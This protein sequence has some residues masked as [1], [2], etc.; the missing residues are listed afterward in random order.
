MRSLLFA[1]RVLLGPSARI[2][3]GLF[4]Y[5][6]KKYKWAG[7]T[8]T[9][10]YILSKIMPALFLSCIVSYLVFSV[11]LVSAFEPGVYTIRNFGA[12]A[13]AS[14]GPPVPFIYLY[15]DLPVN[16]TNNPR[17]QDHWTVDASSNTEYR[18]SIETSSYATIVKNGSVFVSINGAANWSINS[19]VVPGARSLYT[20]SNTVGYWKLA[21]ENA[22]INIVT[23]LHHDDGHAYW[24]FDK[25]S[26]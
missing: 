4:H 21:S 6:A 14:V 23:E 11:W 1:S 5:V 18:V 19:V 15:P 13:N 24:S 22:Q 7:L 8:G 9:P 16:G 20:I 12:A 25:S 17:I 3:P 2:I 10:P 26:E